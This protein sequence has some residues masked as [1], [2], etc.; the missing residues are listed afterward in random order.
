MVCLPIIPWDYR[1]QRPQQLMVRLGAAGHRVFYVHPKLRPRG[2]A[3]VLEEKAANVREVSLH[4]PS[5]NVY[6]ESLRP[7][8]VAMVLASLEALGLR[9]AVTIAQLPFW[10]PVALEARA[11]F[12]W[13]V[14]YDLMDHHA[15]FAAVG[16]EMVRAE[17]QLLREADLVVVSSAMLEQR[18]RAAARRI[19]LLRN[20]C[21]AEFFARAGSTVNAR[22]VIGYFGAIS[23]WFDVALVAELARRRTDWDFLL[24]G[25]TWNTNVRALRRLPNV[26][27]AGEQPYASLPQWIERFDACII[28]FRRTP[29]TEATNPVK[30]YEML[31]SGR[32]VV[33]VPLPEVVALTPHVRLA[34][35]PVEF[36]RELEAAL[37]E[38]DAA[39]A[40]SRRAF[41]RG[42]TWDRRAS[43][44]LAAIQERLRD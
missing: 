16:S 23:E 2:P 22:P 36:E 35:T 27:L 28:P 10:T 6:R 14:V 9:T 38:R 8:E 25:S 18:A 43:E 7:G 24:V 19:L 44:L 17:P 31:A 37:G 29:L 32:P 40:E 5:L 1:F 4:G 11:R 30:A 33:S 13:P 21:D 34:G 20:A 12:G 39:H 26:T 15:G 3:F 42:E 41:A